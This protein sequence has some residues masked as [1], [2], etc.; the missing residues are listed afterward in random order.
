MRDASETNTRQLGVLVLVAALGLAFAAYAS[1][2]TQLGRMTNLAVPADFD[3]VYVQF[4]IDDPTRC[5]VTD[6]GG[7]TADRAAPEL[8]AARWSC[9]RDDTAGEEALLALDGKRASF[10]FVPF[11][12]VADPV[13]PLLYE[14][15]RPAD[16]PR[17]LPRLRWVH[18][19]VD[20]TY[21]GFYLQTTLPTRD[22]FEDKKLGELEL[23]VVGGDRA[24]C[25]DRKLRGLCPTYTGLIAESLFPQPAFSPETA[26]LAGLLPRD[27]PRTFLLSDQAG[28]EALRSWPLPF[29]LPPLVLADVKPF[30]DHRFE[31]WRPGAPA[32]QLPAT[33]RA[34][35]GGASAVAAKLHAALAAACAV[36]SCDAAALGQNIDRSPSLAALAGVTP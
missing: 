32:A 36:R 14:A 27:L 7:A 19:Y 1:R 26:A 23:L 16:G 3:Q 11:E 8:S 30:F 34:V 29:A 12:Q 35:A 6:R 13:Y 20:R 2:H 22:F 4:K 25:F 24:Y 15:W 17:A 21:R 31:T 5:L 28:P 10:L 18:L 9:R 33:V